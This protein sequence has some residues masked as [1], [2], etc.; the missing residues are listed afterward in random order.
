VAHGGVREG[1]WRGNWR[2]EWVA[3]TLHT[4]S[5]HGVSSITTAEEH[6]SAASSDWTDAPA[7]LKGLVRFGERRNLISVCV[8]SHFNWPL[9]TCNPHRP[10]ITNTTIYFNPLTPKDPYSGRNAPLTSKRCILYI[11]STNTGTEYIKYGIH[12]P[13]FFLFKM[14]SV[15]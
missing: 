4:T 3:N 7:D 14:Q 8:P 2:M 13:F 15:S 10:K 5:E 12:C 9:P 1:K 6:I 11:Y